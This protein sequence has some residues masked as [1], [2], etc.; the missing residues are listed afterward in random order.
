MIHITTTRTVLICNYHRTIRSHS[1]S[2]IPSIS[3]PRISVK[4]QT[5]NLEVTLVDANGFDQLLKMT[6]KQ[7]N[8]KITNTTQMSFI[9]FSMTD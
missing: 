5:N 6:D 2:S 9:D 1:L 4:D 7:I 8:Y 3:P